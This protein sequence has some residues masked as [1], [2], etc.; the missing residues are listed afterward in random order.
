MEEAKNQSKIVIFTLVI[1]VLILVN[2]GIFYTG[3]ISKLTS[4]Y[5]KNTSIK[6]SQPIELNSTVLDKL[7]NRK[8]ID[9]SDGLSPKSSGR[10]NPFTNI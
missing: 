1:I 2:F 5:T 9:V 4:D 6:T 3:R 7:S 8:S 10:V